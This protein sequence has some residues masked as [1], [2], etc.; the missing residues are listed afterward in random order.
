MQNTSAVFERSYQAEHIREN[1]LRSRFMSQYADEEAWH[2]EALERAM[3]TMILKSDPNAPIE[4]SNQYLQSFELRR[5]VT[6]FRRDI[7][8][9]KANGDRNKWRPVYFRLKRLVESLSKQAVKHMRTKYFERADRLRALGQS[10]LDETASAVAAVL[11]R[12]HVNPCHGGEALEQLTRYIQLYNDTAKDDTIRPKAPYSKDWYLELLVGYLTNQPVVAKM[13]EVTGVARLSQ[14]KQRHT[15]LLCR[16]AYES[17]DSLTGHCKNM[18]VKKGGFDRPFPC[19]ECRRCGS[20]DDHLITS[21]SSWSCHV[22][23]FH[24]CENAPMLRTDPHPTNLETKLSC[25]FCGLYVREG[26]GF[27][28]HRTSHVRDRAASTVFASPFPCLACRNEQVGDRKQ[29]IMIDGCS[30]WN[31][32]VSLAHADADGNWFVEG[33]SELPG[34]SDYNETALCLLCDDRRPFASHKYLTTHCNTVHVKNGKKFDKPFLCPECRRCNM[35]DHSIISPSLWSS[36]VAMVHGREN[37]P[38]LRTAPRPT[39]DETKQDAPRNHVRESQPLKV[40]PS[41]PNNNTKAVCFLCDN[42]RSFYSKGNLTAHCKTTHLKTGRFK[43]PFLCPECRRCGKPDY[44]ITTPSSWSCHVETAHGQNNA[45][46]LRTD[47]RPVSTMLCPFCGLVNPVNGSG[48]HRSGH[49][50]DGVSSTIF[51]SPFPCQACRSSPQHGD[52]QDIMIEGCSAWNAHVLSTHSEHSRVWTVGI[53]PVGS[54][55]KRGDGT[56]GNL[57]Q[58][59]I[60]D[61]SFPHR[62]IW[63]HFMRTH[64]PTLSSGSVICL[65]CSGRHPGE[66]RLPAVVTGVDAWNEHLLSTHPNLLWEF[67]ASRSSYAI[68]EPSPSA[69]TNIV[70]AGKRRKT[71]RT[72]T[73]TVSPARLTSSSIQWDNEWQEVRR[74]CSTHDMRPTSPWEQLGIDILSMDSTQSDWDDIPLRAIVASPESWEGSHTLKPCKSVHISLI[75][76]LLLSDEDKEMAA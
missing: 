11:Q 52:D 8:K 59:I 74:D 33:P 53:N 34:S 26:I 57:I 14:D 6:E 3:R 21:P 55:R 76:P 20:P 13:Q 29:D 63:I 39:L 75:D 42:M 27:N 19:P 25:P 51:S 72:R 10:T 65:E 28:V 17:L 35:P 44:S 41:I 16:Q 18:H 31:E 38:K 40:L 73:K 7:E 56:A 66:E 30:A 12:K 9:G 62:G 23:M 60:C 37:M 67:R 2:S 45:P 70:Q 50:R 1:L 5:D 4:P 61:G 47:P 46:T 48:K 32:H 69:H 64:L 36:H 24:G 54:K 68:A 43:K 15:C 49:V 71:K 22:E 58:C